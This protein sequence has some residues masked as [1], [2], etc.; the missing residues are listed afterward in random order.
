MSRQLSRRHAILAIGASMLMT[1]CSSRPPNP[2]PGNLQ[3]HALAA[4]R[5]FAVLPPRAFRTGWH[6]KAPVW[7]DGWFVG[8]G[9][10]GGPTV[11][12]TFKSRQTPDYVYR[13]YAARAAATGWTPWQQTG[14]PGGRPATGSWT[15]Q[16]TGQ[17]A[18]NQALLNLFLYHGTFTLSASS[19]P[20]NLHRSQPS[21]NLDG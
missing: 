17:L 4:D 16:L 12:L 10:S 20:Y 1:A 3:L 11:L 2:D 13:F 8:A 6:E 14:V 19:G 15:K 18:G 21:G 5:I 7:H 9:W